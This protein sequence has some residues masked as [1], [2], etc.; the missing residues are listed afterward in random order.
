MNIVVAGK[1]YPM[2]FGYGCLR[3]VCEYYGYNKVSGFDKLIKKLKL[4][5]VDDPNFEQ[6]DFIGNLILAAIE[7][8]KPKAPPEVDDIIDVLLCNPNLIGQVFEEFQ[9]S[10]PKANDVNPDTRGK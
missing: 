1:R 9:K 8:L 6:L 7:N 10:L 3:K 5:K 4:D 2:K